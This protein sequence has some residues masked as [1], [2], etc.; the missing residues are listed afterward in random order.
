MGGFFLYKKEQYCHF[1]HFISDK[2]HLE[3]INQTLAKGFSFYA[4][5]VNQLEPEFVDF[6]FKAA[7]TECENFNKLCKSQM[8]ISDKF[9][10]N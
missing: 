5:N 8:S 6:A 7:G 2:R 3:D 4:M 9:R 1:E 10:F